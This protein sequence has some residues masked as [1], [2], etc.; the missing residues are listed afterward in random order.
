MKPALLRILLIA[1]LVA[2]QL[3]TMMVVLYGMRDSTAERF[4]VNSQ[5]S[6]GRLADLVTEEIGGFLVPAKTTIELTGQLALDGAIDPVDPVAMQRYMLAQL[7]ANPTFHALVMGYPDGRMLAVQREAEG[8]AT[9]LFATPDSGATGQHAVFGNDLKLISSQEWRKPAPF[10]PRLR[11]WY[12]HARAKSGLT[13]TDP[14]IFEPAQQAG[15]TA[16]AAI[17]TASGAD[18]GVFGVDIETRALSN[19]VA[20]IPAVQQG[21]A[22]MVDR[23][24]HLIAM[25]ARPRPDSLVDQSRL[26]RLEEVGGQPLQDLFD[27]H[28]RMQGQREASAATLA[29]DTLAPRSPPTAERNVVRFTSEGIDR[30]GLVLPVSVFGDR[31]SWQLIVQ[32]PVTGMTSQVTALFEEQVPTLGLL[33]V[34]PGL[35]SVVGVLTLT[36]P[37]YKLHE[38][39]TVDKLTSALNRPTFERRLDGMARARRELEAGSSIALVALDLDGFKQINDTHGHGAGDAVLREF[40][41]RLRARLRRDDLI[42]RLGGDEF[43]SAMRFDQREGA[44]TAIEKVRYSVSAAPFSAAGIAL[45]VG[46]TAGLAWLEPGESVSAAMTRA[47]RAL[48]VGKSI[49]KGRSYA[50]NGDG[51]LNPIAG[52]SATDARS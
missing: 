2:V 12:R 25:S 42:G 41:H 30:I 28:R 13:W 19:Y 11:P 39:A 38:Q 44:L 10:D 36:A 14:Y 8:F 35:L 49:R 29:L 15:I 32:T 50:M 17:E 43:M 6:L 40:V 5:D 4:V 21:T 16:A 34:L 7:K 22:A 51:S 23:E 27:K 46:V 9:W 3:V 24:G 45:P 26:P 47:D 18:A 31:P 1:L 33:I 20:R 52:A 37:L 48:V